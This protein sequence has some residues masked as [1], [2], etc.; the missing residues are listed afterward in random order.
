MSTAAK[1]L[2]G[3]PAARRRNRAARRRRFC[4]ESVVPV[5]MS[6]VF[7]NFLFLSPDWARLR[8]ASA[9]PASL[10]PLAASAATHPRTTSRSNLRLVATFAPAHPRSPGCKSCG[11][12]SSIKKSSSEPAGKF[13][14]GSAI[15]SSKYRRTDAIAASLVGLVN[16]TFIIVPQPS[17][18]RD[19]TRSAL[20]TVCAGIQTPQTKKK[21]RKAQMKRL[22]DSRSLFLFPDPWL[23]L[24]RTYVSESRSCQPRLSSSKMAQITPSP[25]GRMLN[26]R[27]TSRAHRCARVGHCPS[28]VHRERSA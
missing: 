13:P 6:P 9:F 21:I 23:Y 25:A 27:A 4:D 17:L 3:N 24:L 1:L 11:P 18:H 19:Y 22:P 5:T 7:A 26:N 12:T 20:R 15:F 14:I 8:S 28:S 10:H 16:S 2:A